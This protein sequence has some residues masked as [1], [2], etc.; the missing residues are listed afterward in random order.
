[1]SAY[2]A[3]TAESVFP[4]EFTFCTL[5][6]DFR[7]YEKFLLSCEN[8]GF[9]QQDCEFLIVDN[10]ESNQMDAYAAINRMLAEARGRYVVL[11]HQD[12]ELLEARGILEHQLAYL[13]VH[14]PDWALAGNAGGDDRQLHIRITDPHGADQHSGDLPARV[15]SLDENFIVVNGARR[16]AASG[17]MRGFHLYG[18]DLCVVADVLGYSSWVI[19]FHVL[20][21]SRGNVGER[22]SESALAFYPSRQRLV[23]KYRRAFR[24]RRV[25]T[26]CTR[27]TLA[28]ASADSRVG[29]A[30]ATLFRRFLKGRR[31]KPGV[32]SD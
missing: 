23:D 3:V 26:T 19:G 16:I 4:V 28:P 6:T 31:T 11:C 24:R 8:M 18:L 27:V 14:A 20:H 15:F 7:E 17:D 30:V 5:V 25:R 32:T 10:T 21:K 2:T 22:D 1:M 13:E 12:V 9:C 29:Q